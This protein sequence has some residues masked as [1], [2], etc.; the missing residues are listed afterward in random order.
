M[1]LSIAK[2]TIVSLVLIMLIHHLYD[3]LQ[4]TLTVPRTRDL[5]NRPAARYREMAA[6]LESGSTARGER[7]RGMKDELAEF[8]RDLKKTDEPRGMSCELE[9][10]YANFTSALGSGA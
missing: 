9:P 1:M 6:A 7:S 3:F 10:S 8:L 2:W 4:G 5:V